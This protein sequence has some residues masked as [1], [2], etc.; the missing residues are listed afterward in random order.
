[1][2]APT[3]HGKDAARNKDE[4]MT[5]NEHQQVTAAYDVAWRAYLRGQIDK[6]ALDSARWEL[7]KANGAYADALS[8]VASVPHPAPVCHHCGQPDCKRI[9][10]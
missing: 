7:H 9:R 4:P 10:E 6:Q 8:H 2:A 5:H 1:M 3:G